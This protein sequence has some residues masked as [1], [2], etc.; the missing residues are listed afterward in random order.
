MPGKESRLVNH[1]RLMPQRFRF[2]CVDSARQ[3]SEA[4]RSVK[5]AWG[6]LASH[7][8]F[9]FMNMSTL[10]ASLPAHL[11]GK[12]AD[13]QLA[14]TFVTECCLREPGIEATIPCTSTASVSITFHGCLNR[15]N[16]L[17]YR[18]LKIC[19]YLSTSTD[20]VAHLVGIEMK[21]GLPKT[22]AVDPEGSQGKSICLLRARWEIKYRFIWTWVKAIGGLIH[23]PSLSF[24]AIMMQQLQNWNQ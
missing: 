20:D 1:A 13:S 10:G 5:H 2:S 21:M 4:L 7:V 8:Q 11:M 12:W 6:S 24:R 17:L 9:C 23:G 18:S 3:R 14:Q 22:V 19:T 16:G 15:I